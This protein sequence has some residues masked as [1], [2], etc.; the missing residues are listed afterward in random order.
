MT[1]LAGTA[2]A[3][4]KPLV[5]DSRSDSSEGA[6]TSSISFG[7]APAARERAGGF[8]LY[9]GLSTP[10]RVAGSLLDGSP[11]SLAAV[12]RGGKHAQISPTCHA[13][14]RPGSKES[15]LDTDTRT[16]RK[17]SSFAPGR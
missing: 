17:F 2:R 8:G 14:F 15:V 4:A 10:T 3:R 16:S 5:R 12:H 6:V 7:S 11:S 1:S 13:G 9:I